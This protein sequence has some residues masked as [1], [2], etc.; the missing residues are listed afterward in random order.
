M[1]RVALVAGMMASASA[2]EPAPVAAVTEATNSS[3]T[4]VERDRATTRGGLRLS[5]QLGLVAEDKAIPRGGSESKSIVPA[6]APSRPSE[7]SDESSSEA[8]AIET[9]PDAERRIV[10][11]T[12]EL[13]RAGV[14]PASRL[15]VLDGTVVLEAGEAAADV[16]AGN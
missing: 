12:G 10:L 1:W 9:S 14:V 4:R 11:P 8:S 15:K 3:P 2:Q 7:A 5:R 13:N 16:S 6:G